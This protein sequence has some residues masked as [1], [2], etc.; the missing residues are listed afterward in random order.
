MHHHRD[1]HEN[2]PLHVHFLSALTIILKA[3]GP[4]NSTP[5]LRVFCH[6]RHSP[7]CRKLRPQTE[8]CCPHAGRRHPPPGESLGPA[9]GAVFPGECEWS[10]GSRTGFVAEVPGI[11]GQGWAPHGHCRGAEEPQH[12]HHPRRT[13]TRRGPLHLNGTMKIDSF[14][15]D[16]HYGTRLWQNNAIRCFLPTDNLLLITQYLMILPFTTICS[17]TV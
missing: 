4:F 13:G 8:R 14:L 1:H 17:I 7:S 5:K 15:Q 2:T 16:Y 3:T 10:R 6:F 11:W 12:C 9:R